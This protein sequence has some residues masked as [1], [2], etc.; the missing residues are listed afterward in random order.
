M[1][2]AVGAQGPNGE[3]LRLVCLHW[4]LFPPPSAVR[5]EDIEV[6]RQ[7]QEVTQAEYQQHLIW[8]RICGLTRM[9][10]KKCRNCPQ[11]RHLKQKNHLWVLETPDGK[12]AVPVVDLPTLESLSRRRDKPPVGNVAVRASSIRQP[13]IP[14]RKT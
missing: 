14:G 6:Q 13:Y 10:R 12:T 9:D 4:R 7:N 8:K 2:N 5:T 3:E 11:V 1:L